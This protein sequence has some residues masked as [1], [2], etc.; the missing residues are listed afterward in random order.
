MRRIPAPVRRAVQ[1]GQDIGRA[2]A[3]VRFCAVQGTERPGTDG[4]PE[5][6]PGGDAGRVFRRGAETPDGDQLRRLLGNL[7]DRMGADSRLGRA[8]VRG[9]RGALFAVLPAHG[10]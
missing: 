10:F 8:A 7:P 4:V 9:R 6:A 5:R 2:D 1:R 3:A